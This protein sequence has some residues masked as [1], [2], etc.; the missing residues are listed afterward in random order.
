MQPLHPHKVSIVFLVEVVYYLFCLAFYS[1]VLVF[2]KVFIKGAVCIFVY[3]TIASLYPS[4]SLFMNTNTLKYVG[5]INENRIGIC[6][7][8][9]P[10]LL[11]RSVLW[12]SSYSRDEIRWGRLD[13]FASIWIYEWIWCHSQCLCVF[14]GCWI[15]L[16]SFV[17]L[18]THYF[19]CSV[20]EYEY[21]HI[22]II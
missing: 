18:L 2:L 12:R 16:L 3:S 15:E 4:S 6:V 17:P 10:S 20:Y 8:E 19:D 13:F 5:Y 21:I 9:Y 22:Y 1:C 7:F 11:Y 14:Y